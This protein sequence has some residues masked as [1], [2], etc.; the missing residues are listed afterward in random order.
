MK[1][2]WAAMRSQ[3]E[4][5]FLITFHGF[6]TAWVIVQNLVFPI[7]TLRKFVTVLNYF[8]FL[9]CFI[10]PVFLSCL[11]NLLCV[12]LKQTSHCSYLTILVH[13]CQQK[14]IRLKFSKS[15]TGSD[16]R[17]SCHHN[18]SHFTFSIFAHSCRFSVVHSLQSITPRIY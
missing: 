3:K 13:S 5:K 2:F 7:N 16:V 1:L 12:V 9:Q 17:Y 8:Q 11:H 10:P 6:P 14:S 18:S 4:Y 15:Q